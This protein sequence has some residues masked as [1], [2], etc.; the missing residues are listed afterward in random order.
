MDGW[1]WDAPAF[2]MEKIKMKILEGYMPFKGYQTYYRVVG[3]GDKTPIVCLHGGPGST[4]N[5]FE[6]LDELAD[7]GHPIIMYDQLGCGNSF[8]EGHDEL[9]NQE[10]WLEELVCLLEYLHIDACHLLGQS[11]GGMLAIAYAIEKKCSKLSSLIL[12]STLSSASLWASEQ[13]RMI[14]LMDKKEQEA[15]L[16][17]DYESEE[18]IKANARYMELHCSGPF[19]ENTPECVKREK[20]SG[21]RSYLIGWGP[22]EYTPLGTLK[23]F[24]YTSRLNEIT[25]PSL[26]ISGT[27]DLCTPLVA[28]TMYNHIPNSKWELMQGC[29]HMCFVDDHDKYCEIILDW[30]CHLS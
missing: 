14:R 10:T 16:S 5:Y 18:Y 25:V 26:V 1:C 12:S 30:I 2:L 28:K 3:D 17:S 8:V 6:V 13:H 15:V 27:D 29:R 19:D 7:S 4:H 9:W 20:V 24:E 21:A 23:N 22:N 11:W